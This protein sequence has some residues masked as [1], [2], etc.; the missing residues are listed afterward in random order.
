MTPMLFSVFISC[1]ALVPIA[2][3]VGQYTHVTC[4]TPSLCNNDKNQRMCCRGAGNCMRIK[5]E[6]VS[7]FT[8]YIMAQSM[9]ERSILSCFV[10]VK[11][12]KNY[13]V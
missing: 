10:C 11:M 4:T 13:K 3:Y 8:R 7:H 1:F 9:S 2:K 5:M 12:C 6:K